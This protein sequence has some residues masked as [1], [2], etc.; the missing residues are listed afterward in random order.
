MKNEYRW[1][2]IWVVAAMALVLGTS[3]WAKRDAYQFKFGLM[4]RGSQGQSVVYLETNQIE[5]IADPSYLHGFSIKRKDE[6]Q[7]YIYYIVRFPE[8][9]KD[10][11]EG[12][13]N[14]YSVLDGGRVLQSNE[15]FVWEL[16]RSF[17]FSD[18]DPVGQYELEVYVDAELY[19]KINYDVLPELKATF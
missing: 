2:R 3:V 17:V 13:E 6:N 5:K 18:S 1:M 8:P 10:L 16:S 19:R 11:P 9:L 12:I 4:A 7:F 14:Y 15:E